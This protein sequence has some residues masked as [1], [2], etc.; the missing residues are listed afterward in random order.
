MYVF[1]TRLHSRQPT[2]VGLYDQWFRVDKCI[3]YWSYNTVIKIRRMQIVTKFFKRF[4]SSMIKI[5]FYRDLGWKRGDTSLFSLWSPLFFSFTWSPP[6]LL[7]CLTKHDDIVLAILGFI[8]ILFLS[9]YTSYFA[10]KHPFRL[11][12][13]PARGVKVH[14]WR[15][16]SIS[17]YN[18]GVLMKKKRCC[19]MPSYVKQRW[20]VV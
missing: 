8:L 5:W 9:Q 18:L 1:L 19:T 11:E 4:L 17:E 2:S 12:L 7:S 16:W 20:E 15:G 6:F 14:S 3:M 13:F 10:T